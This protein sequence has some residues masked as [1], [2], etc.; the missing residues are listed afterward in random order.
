M[1]E[2]EYSLIEHLRELR[3]C[4]WRALVGLTLAAIACFIVSDD[5]LHILRLPME[6]ALGQ[7]GQF[8]VL[9]PQEYFFAQ[10]KAAV[11]GG[12]FVSSPWIL[13]QLWRFISPGLYRNEKRYSALFVIVGA[14]FFICGAVFCYLAVF[15]PMFRFFIGTLP[16]GVQGT[17]SI[18]MLF[19]F[20]TSILLAFGLVFESP[21]IVFLLVVMDLVE[22]STLKQARPYV[23]VC[24]FVVGATLT[25]P[26]P[27]TQTMLALPMII[28]Y[29]LGLIAARIFMRARSES[30]AST[31]S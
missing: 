30:E 17:Y 28:L 5:I 31:E 22:I 11:V 16:E 29:E 1:D 20:A 8:V 4:L 12:I 19:G 13:Y 10:M 7:A 24:A 3:T 9:A 18:G 6:K 15:P 25:P 26:D 23:F 2:R 21:V 14:F 27:V